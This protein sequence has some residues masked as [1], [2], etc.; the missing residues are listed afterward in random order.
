MRLGSARSGAPQ[1]SINYDHEG[2]KLVL[3]GDDVA[4]I[5]ITSVPMKQDAVQRPPGLRTDV[6][7]GSRTTGVTGGNCSGER[8]LPKVREAY[9]T[10]ALFTVVLES[11]SW[12]TVV[13]L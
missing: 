6:D 3:A 1:I 8:N 4:S 13:L 5:S 9:R 2:G 11:K 7:I 12:T 10:T